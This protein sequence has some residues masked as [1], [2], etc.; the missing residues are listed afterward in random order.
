MSGCSLWDFLR[1]KT[2]IKTLAMRCLFSTYLHG[3]QGGSYKNFDLSNIFFLSPPL[4]FINNDRSLNTG[5]FQ[6]H[7]NCG[8]THPSMAASKENKLPPSFSGYKSHTFPHESSCD[9]VSG[10]DNYEQWLNYSA[11]VFYLWLLQAFSWFQKGSILL[12]NADRS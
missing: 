8:S 2:S 7:N 1:A 11:S 4:L 5:S 10:T 9:G 3:L 6:H 12:V